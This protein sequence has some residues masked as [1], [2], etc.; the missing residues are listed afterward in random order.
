MGFLLLRVSC[1]LDRSSA[2]QSHV[3]SMI[4]RRKTPKL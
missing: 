1:M 2:E 4:N 3:G